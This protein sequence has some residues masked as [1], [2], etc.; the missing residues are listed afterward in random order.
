VAITAA[1]NDHVDA[2]NDAVQRLRLTIG[3]LHRDDG[4]WI[5]GGEAAYPGDVVA[6]RRNN[7]D[8]RTSSGEPVRNRDLWD[9]VFTH[10]D[11]SLSV[12]HRG[13]HGS[14][15]L[16]AEYAHEHVRLGY[17]ATEHGNQADTVDVAIAL[18]STATTYRGLYVGATRGRDENRI[19]V[20]TDTD[21]L[22]AARDVL[23]AVIAHDRADI[24]AVTQRRDLAW[25]AQAAQPRRAEPASIIP[26]WVDP[27]RAQLERRRHDLVGYLSDRSD[28]RAEAAAGLAALQPSLAAARAAWKPFGDA[29]AEVE[30]ALRSGLR[31]AMWKANTAAMH[32][33]FG[34]HH[35]SR[36]RA[37]TATGRVADAETRIAAIHADGADVRQ[38]LDKIEADAANLA[39]LAHPTP[40]AAWLEQLNRDQL[41]NIDG[42][43]D[44]V[45]V[46]TRW[47]HGRPVGVTELHRAVGIVAQAARD[48]PQFARSPSEIDGAQWN[49]LLA[50]VTRLLPGRSIVPLPDPRAVT[51]DRDGPS[52]EL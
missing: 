39:D 35:A 24:P 16:P 18:V 50:P 17:A 1:T 23:E 36:R 5:A 28:R 6:T 20:I 40:A 42:L 51:L 10:P 30:H 32:A 26:G 21:D 43:L 3:Q 2:I 45:A 46:W 11:G 52:I 9:V 41:N 13:G 25:Q 19:H 34:H 12:S 38:Q 22:A 7:R 31:P 47:A 29:I 15:T 14:A 48:A 8:L 4:V 44:A 37:K 49:E 33:G 27:W